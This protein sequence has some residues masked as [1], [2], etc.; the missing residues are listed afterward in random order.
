MELSPPTPELAVSDLAQALDF[1]T[2]RMGFE[3]AWHNAA[4]KI[5]AVHHGDCGIFFRESD[6][7]Q[8][9]GTVW[10]FSEDLDDTYAALIGLNAPIVDPLAEKPWGLRQFTVQDPFG[11]LY[12][13]HHDT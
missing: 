7:D 1:F 13:F 5:A 8:C 3:I 10:I 12:H 11:N 2:S 9:S 6:Q 4:G